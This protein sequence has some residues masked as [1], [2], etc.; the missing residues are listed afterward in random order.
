[1]ADRA[2]PCGESSGVGHRLE[3]GQGGRGRDAF[4]DVFESVGPKDDFRGDG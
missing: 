2:G 1:M 3:A 4:E